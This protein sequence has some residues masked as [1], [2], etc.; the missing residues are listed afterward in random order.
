MPNVTAEQF[1]SVVR[2]CIEYFR[3]EFGITRAEAIGVLDILK[4]E[5]LCETLEDEDEDESE[6]W[7]KG[8]GDLDN[9]GSCC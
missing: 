4:F 8:E 7:K 2:N 1:E 6:A 5:L 9:R 3:G